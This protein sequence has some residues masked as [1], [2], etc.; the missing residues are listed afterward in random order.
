MVKISVA[1]ITLNEERNIGRCLESVKEIADDVVVTDSFSTDKTEEICMQHG[2]RFI[3]HR[4]EGYVE[5]KNVATDLALYDHILSL[6]AD[7]ALSPELLAAIKKVKENFDADAYTMNRLTNYCGHWIKHSGWYPD[8]KLRLFDRRKGRWEG[9]IIHE[10]LKMQAGSVIKH[11]Q[12][13]LLH[14]SFY[15]I[16]EHRRQSEKFTTLGA[17]ADF[18]KGK[19]AS[20]YKIAFSA[21][22]KFLQA[23]IFQL[24]F[25]DGKAGFTISRLSA[26]A[27]YNKYVKLKKLYNQQHE[28]S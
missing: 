3:K 10:E 8:T 20:W 13:D 28:N 26:A 1:I 25:L 11:L 4:W 27:T 7:E 2:A 19:R 5:Q 23:F 9:L 21:P 12:G 15:T 16:E 22:V 24:G 6:D 17:E 18:K 14:Y